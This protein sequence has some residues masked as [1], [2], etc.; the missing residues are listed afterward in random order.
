M[1]AERVAPVTE[2]RNTYQVT[3]VP[4][5]QGWELHVD[6]VGVTQSD[7]LDDAEMMARDLIARRQGVAPRS[8]DVRVTPQLADQRLGEKAAR[9]LA[10]IE[11]RSVRRRGRWLSALLGAGHVTRSRTRVGR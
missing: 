9:R 2:A 3:A 10:D 5:E 6:G 11:H 4:W 7:T 8:F 1:P